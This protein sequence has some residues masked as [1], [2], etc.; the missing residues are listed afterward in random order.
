MA[1]KPEAQAK[2][3]SYEILGPLRVSVGGRPLALGGRRQPAALALL[4][5]NHN[6]VTGTDQLIRV[7]WGDDPPETAVGQVQTLMWRLRGQLGE[8]AILT[9]PGGYE[10]RAPVE[11]IDAARFAALAAEG[12]ELARAGRRAAA[13]DRLG[14]ALALWRG[15]VLAD[16]FVPGDR[17]AG[18]LQAAA[19]ELAEQRL[20]AQRELLDAELALGRHAELIPRLSRLVQSEPMREELRERLMLALYRAGRR[21]EALAVFR[22]GRDAAVT[23]LGLEPG[24]ALQELHRRILDAD[25]GLDLDP[26]QGATQ[27]CEVPMDVADLVGQDELA[28]ELCDV[29]LREQGLPAIVA[30]SGAAGSG[31]TTL[32]VHLA[33]LVRGRFPGGQLFV[34]LRGMDAPAEPAVVLARLLRSLGVD[35]RLI[36][37]EADE[38]AAL[39]R[40]RTNGKRVLIVLD[41]AAG[42]AQV[43]PLL[44]AAP[45]CAVLITSRRR[46]AGLPAA[47]HVDLGVFTPEQSLD[48]LDRMIGSARVGRERADCLRVAQ[49]CGYLPLAIRIAG[50]RLAARPHWPVARLAE[51]LADERARLDVL[52]TGDLEVRSSLA[53]GFAALTEPQRR[54]LCLTGA[55]SAPAVPGWVAAALLDLPATEGEELAESL[56]DARFVDVAAPGR[57]RLHDLVRAFS[58]ERLPE[59]VTTTETATALIRTVSAWLALAEIAHERLPGGFRQLVRDPAKRWN[60]W[61]RSDLAAM[62]DDPARW[63]E[64]ERA[65]LVGA[66]SHAA[67]LATT[68]APA[69]RARAA[70]LAWSLATTLARFF[71]LREHLDDWRLTHDA[72][73]AA[74]VSTGDRRGEAYV[75]RGLGELHL[76]LDRLDLASAELGEALRLMR[77]I[78]DDGGEAMVLRAIGTVQRLSGRHQEAMVTLAR[79]E[80]LCV[81]LGDLVGRAQVLHNIG[82]VH[83]L[84]GR[85]ADAERSYRRALAIFERAGDRF[86][87]AFTLSSLG[88]MH[89]R[90]PGRALEVEQHLRRAVQLCLELHYRRGAGIALGHLGDLHLRQGAAELAIGE[91]RQALAYCREVGDTY[92]ECLEL[93]RLG[94][95]HLAAGQAGLA[96]TVLAQA[97]EA[98][99]GAGRED[100][101]AAIAAILSGL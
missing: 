25:P 72:A 41:N 23:E 60:R 31:K 28:R 66:V 13:A 92:N 65:G 4:L 18:G 88:M 2:T 37:A 22:Q 96:K 67:E 84:A 8:A 36:P 57:Y 77:E 52:R 15:P 34:D 80:Q 33:H 29:L 44:P 85:E 17:Q 42:Q 79:A 11:A 49:R 94:Q 27:V 93:R 86:G 9:H 100:E 54:L 16:L 32:A 70:G 47:Y 81:R 10:L 95:A 35:P 61:E 74:C 69:L 40:A 1:G 21:P 55:V 89:R 87:E 48:L 58:Q 7:L 82:A 68:A 20:A 64:Q 101:H 90:T 63:C 50:A 6:R 62:L 19:S 46:L 53:L 59:Q 30:V 39:F 5:V 76:N 51:Q 91:L 12:G 3:V 97:L 14:Q 24:R 56:A 83:R 99:A 38:R 45:G 26:P 78:G 75:R 98:A 71:E 43:R 73:L